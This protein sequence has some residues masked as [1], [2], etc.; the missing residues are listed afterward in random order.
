RRYQMCGLQLR[1][2]PLLVVLVL[3]AGCRD[4][5]IN[6]EAASNTSSENV[7]VE[8]T[9]TGLAKALTEFPRARDKNTIFKFADKDYV[10][11]SDGEWEN[12][13]EADKFLSEVLEQINLG[14]QV[15]ISHQ[16]SNIQV[17]VLGDHAWSIYDF[18][19]KVG[20]NGFA[21]QEKQGKCTAIL[22][23]AEGRWL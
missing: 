21:V 15:G 5:V 10:G 14:G 2:L 13:E 6:A 11:I 20:R 7:A 12:A 17:E 4:D 18:S 1:A 3:M 19:F 22:K 8:A 23:K 16:V 9:I